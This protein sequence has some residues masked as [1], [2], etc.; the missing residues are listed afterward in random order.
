MTIRIG[1]MGYGNLGRGVENAIRQ[2]P[3]TTLAAIF[4]RRDPPSRRSH[5]ASLCAGQARRRGMPGGKK[6]T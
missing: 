2:N 4:T 6:L 5:R 3:D 1:I